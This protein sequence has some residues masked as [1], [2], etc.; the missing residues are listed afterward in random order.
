M[1]LEME[2]ETKQHLID[3][4]G[5]HPDMIDVVIEASNELNLFVD[6]EEQQE[7]VEAV[8]FYHRTNKSFYGVYHDEKFHKTLGDS[9]AD[10]I[11]DNYGYRMKMMD[12]NIILTRIKQNYKNF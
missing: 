10:I 2:Q 4:Y 11:K 6:D 3:D 1:S 12:E 7:F 9:M 5:V 8:L